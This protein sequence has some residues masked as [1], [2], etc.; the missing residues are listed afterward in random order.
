MYIG[1]AEHSVLHL[2]YTRFLTMALHD[3]GK[4]PFEEPF[5]RF[6]AHGLI[7]KDG[8]KMAKSVG[9][10]I[11]PDEYIETYGADALRTYLMFMGPYEVGGDFSDRGIGGVVRF[12]ERVWR[13]ATKAAESTAEDAKSAVISSGLPGAA[14]HTA[15]K[16]VGEDI[17]ALKY[18]TAIAALMEYVNALEVQPTVSRE[19][20]R[21]LLVLLAPFA[22]YVSEELWGRIG[23]SGSVHQQ[24]WPAYDE[25]ALRRAVVTL[26]VQVDGRLRDRI[27]MSVD[28]S[29]EE[30]RAAALASEKVRRAIGDRPIRDVIYVA[31]R[32]ANVVTAG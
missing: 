30:V 28:A 7:I 6:R 29:P 14:M 15:I 32:L 12:L 25:A 20:V 23:E 11:N 4:L 13:L 21:A 26:V 9:N 19:E 16:R 10:V 24:P 22:P 17:P 1:G 8:A 5:R 31:G 18:N 27:E 3:L 2:L